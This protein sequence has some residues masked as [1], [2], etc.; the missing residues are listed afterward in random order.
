MHW[1]A[2]SFEAIWLAVETCRVVVE[3]EGLASSSFTT[4][5]SLSVGLSDSGSSQ[6]LLE[7]Y[8]SS[9]RN[10]FASGDW[11]SGSVK[12]SSAE[13]SVESNTRLSSL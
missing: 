7:Q 5:S 6:W 10:L 3:G 2:G 9:K 11:S 8:E 4:G 12:M 1:V 13:E